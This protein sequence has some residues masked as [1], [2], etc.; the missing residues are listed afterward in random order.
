VISGAK[1]RLPELNHPMPDAAG[2]KSIVFWS[3]SWTGSLV[4]CL[5]NIL[6]LERS[7]TKFIA[8]TQGLDTIQR[9]DGIH[10]PSEIL[11]HR[12][13]AT[14]EFPNPAHPRFRRETPASTFRQAANH[15][16]SGHRICIHEGVLARIADDDFREY[17]GLR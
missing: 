7:D 15:S 4:D 9:F 2:P 16:A 12:D 14:A 17:P 5:N 10:P 8:V 3:G 11:G 1:C 13:M 6:A